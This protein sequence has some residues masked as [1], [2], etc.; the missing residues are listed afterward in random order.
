MNGC[1][2][3]LNFIIITLIFLLEEVVKI[4][5]ITEFVSGASKM[6]ASGFDR[7]PS[8]CFTDSEM[9]PTSSTCALTITFPRQYGLL[10]YE[11]F[12]EKLNLCI[13]NSFGFGSI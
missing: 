6:P 8:V 7:T 5:D 10:T 12:K 1:C 9:L 2:V 4:S 11:Y 3:T 13:R